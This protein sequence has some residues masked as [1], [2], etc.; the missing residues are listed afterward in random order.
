LH[1][2]LIAFALLWGCSS[3]E[4]VRQAAPAASPRSSAAAPLVSTD[5]LS[6]EEIAQAIADTGSLIVDSTYDEVTG[7]L[8]EQA[9]QHYLAALE[10][11]ETGDS[12]R[13]AA[14]FEYAIGILNEISYYPNIEANKDFNDLSHSVIEDYE[15]YIATIDDLGAQTSIFALRQKLTDMTELADSVGQDT[16]RSIITTT[17]IPLVINGHVEQNI[18]FFQGK[19]KHHFD[20]WLYLSGKYFPMMREIFKQEGAPQE[21]V[22]LSMIESGL[23]P[24]A[25]SWAKAVGLWQFIKG[26]GSLYGLTGNFWY[27]DRRDFEKATRAAARH[28]NDLHQEFGDWYLALAAYNSGGGRV[29]RAIRRSGS[30]DFWRM[31]PFLPRETRN[32]VPQYIA[33][34]V[35][36][37]NPGTYG[38]DVTP[39][40]PIM[41]DTVTVND[42]VDLAVLA[43]C[44]ESDEATMRELNPALVQ[45][46]TPPGTKGFTLRIPPGRAALF[47]SKY[48]ALPDEQKQDWMAHTVKKRETLG[49]IAKKY[50][51]TKML[52]AECNKLEVGQ[53]IAAGR[54]LR[55]PVAASSKAYAMNMPEETTRKPAAKSKKRAALLA[56]STRGKAKVSYTVRANDNL[57]QIAE[58][59]NARVSDLRLWN[60]IPYG[61]MVRVGDEL[62]VWVAK[63]LARDYARI[64]K[65]SDQERTSTLASRASASASSKRATKAGTYWTQYVVQ[66]GDNLGAIASRFS[67][68]VEDLRRWNGLRTNAISRGRSL[69]VLIEDQSTVSRRTLASA[70]SPTAQKADSDAKKG[71]I[72]YKVKKGDTLHSIA[73]SFGVSIAKLQTWNKLRTKKIHVGQELLIYS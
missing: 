19:G 65:M 51:I 27:D 53:K 11:E 14:E 16:P 6:R 1:G 58:L 62:N 21:L 15:K 26:T 24:A 48:A 56:Q 18:S 40:D 57:S 29:Y 52:L 23:N 70:P 5:T 47:A 17:T 49:S 55:I 38:F 50:G 46:C 66:K 31:R 2:F 73:S 71:V 72:S 42:C 22:Y 32:Y 43:K 3:N 4:E 45:W 60:E 25:H 13:S 28:L 7:Q 64:D 12:A 37:M 59:F 44:A 10:A 61:T 36:G 8:L 20:R 9:R 35:M 67:V 69:E 41:F 34:T 39:G 33:A 68:S 63:D 54:V 30:R